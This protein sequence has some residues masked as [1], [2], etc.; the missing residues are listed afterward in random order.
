MSL[1]FVMRVGLLCLALF[2]FPV[3]SKEKPV[4]LFVFL[5]NRTPLIYVVSVARVLYCECRGEPDVGKT[6]VIDV[7]RNR[8]Q[9]L[10]K[11]SMKGFCRGKVDSDLFNFASNGLKRPVSHDFI[12]FLNADTATNERWLKMAIN[13]PGK[14]IGRHWFFK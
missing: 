5:E 13:K 7:M 14:M 4:G 12:Y 3:L 9:D 2:I 10:V 8:G 1:Q 6:A 11:I